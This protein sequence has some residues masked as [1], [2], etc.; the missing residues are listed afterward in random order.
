MRQLSIRDVQ[1]SVT[2]I[3]NVSL[4]D[5]LGVRRT[6]KYT[7]PR[8]IAMWLCGELLT[9]KSL[10]QIARMFCRDHTTIGHGIRRGRQITAESESHIKNVNK[11]IS[12][13]RRR[14]E[15]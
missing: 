6:R 3:F 9:D 2:T 12:D 13:L 5:I 10:S 14:A 11:I 4:A 7:D 15:I 8:Q 1:E